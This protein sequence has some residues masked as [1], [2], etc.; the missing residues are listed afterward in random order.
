VK[1]TIQDEK[2][3][4]TIAW[5]VSGFHLVN[6][7]PKGQ[8]FNGAYYIAQLLTPLLDAGLYPPGVELIIHAANT[9]VHTVR[10][11]REFMKE[12]GLSRA[13]HSL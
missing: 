6:V 4:V 8:K 10:K 13:P 7:L 12:S 3:M 9:R 11:C 5:G 2:V 1:H